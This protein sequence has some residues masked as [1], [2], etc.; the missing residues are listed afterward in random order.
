T[1][2]ST[3]SMEA[4]VRTAPPRGATEKAVA[5]VVGDVSKAPPATAAG[6]AVVVAAVAAAVVSAVV[7]GAEVGAEYRRIGPIQRTG[8]PESGGP[9]MFHTK[10]MH[11]QL[12]QWH[13]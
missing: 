9:V 12:Q 8:V 7:V 13:C 2:P 10:R 6:R 1:P 3:S 11:R 4:V 5:A